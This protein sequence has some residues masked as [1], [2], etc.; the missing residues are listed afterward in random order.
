[1]IRNKLKT[2]YYK[3]NEPA[4]NDVSHFSVKK[5]RQHVDRHN[6]GDGVIGSD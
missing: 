2:F 5:R 6:R 1:M 3:Y 4:T